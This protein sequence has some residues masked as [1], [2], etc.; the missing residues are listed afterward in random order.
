MKM[1]AWPLQHQLLRLSKY[2]DT[3]CRFSTR[4]DIVAGCDHYDLALP[5]DSLEVL[6]DKNV[7][8]RAK[9]QTLRWPRL[10]SLVADGHL[11]PLPWKMR[12]KPRISDEP[13]GTVL[14]QQ[15]LTGFFD[16]DGC[17]VSVASNGAAG[18]HSPQICG[19]SVS[20]SYDAADVLMIYQAAFGGGIHRTGYGKGL[21][22]PAVQWQLRDPSGVAS[23]AK[24]LAQHSITKKRQLQ[25]AARWPDARA[26]QE[27]SVAELRSL[28]RFDS[29]YKTACTWEYFTGFFDAEGCIGMNNKSSLFLSLSQ[30]YSSVLECLQDFLVC[31]MGIAPRIRKKTAMNELLIYTTSTCQRILERMLASGMVRKRRQAELALDRKLYDSDDFRVALFG[32]AGNQR[33][34]KRLDKAGVDRARDIRNASCRAARAENRGQLNEAK[35]IL[36]E[37]EALKLE[38]ET[39]NAERE[40]LQ[41]HAYMQDLRHQDVFCKSVHS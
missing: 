38:H 12:G 37:V 35:R 25:I 13:A 30:K 32:L 33:F 2:A 7:R 24:L 6:R 9:L 21:C 19:L 34:G 15:Y 23:A 28:K 5:G 11:Y 1:R 29:A 41:L 10:T 14:G 31:E 16:G 20:Q 26:A 4:A 18:K 8:L 3:R 39:K 17:V 40:N 36:E 27:A 22:K